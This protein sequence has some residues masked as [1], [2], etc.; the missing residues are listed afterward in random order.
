MFKETEN[1]QI[2]LQTDFKL[3]PFILLWKD[4]STTKGISIFHRAQRFAT[5]FTRA[6][7]VINTLY[8]FVTCCWP[9]KLISNMNLISLHPTISCDG[10]LS[11]DTFK[12]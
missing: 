11:K 2:T 12:M 5:V 8:H 9:S 10:C 4:D 1:T 3:I 6:R 7:Q